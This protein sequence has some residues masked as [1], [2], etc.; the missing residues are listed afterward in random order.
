[1]NKTKRSSMMIRIVAVLAVTMMFTMCFVGGTFAKYV[2]SANVNDNQA[3]VA[4][5]GVA[6]TAQDTENTLFKTTYDTDNAS[7]SGSISNSVVSSSAAKL[8]A[9]GTEGGVLKFSVKGTPEVAVN[10]SF[11]M[12]VNSDV[13]IGKDSTEASNLGLDDA[14][15]TPV[16]FTLKKKGVV[17]PVA[18]G[19]LT[20]IKNYLEGATIS[21]D[22][23]AKTDLSTTFGE[24]ELTWAWAFGTGDTDVK[25]TYLGNVAA[26]TIT[27]DKV[28][29][30]IDFDLAITVTQID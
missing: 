1:M 11:A 30:T 6:V 21:K 18:Q 8:V 19:T 24:Y 2:T 23:A 5:W 12:T 16:V 25:D 9:P 7:V 29:T 14:D 3:Q 27:D 15:Y 20:D 10:V 4:K 28:S 17:T 22:Y 13:K 26:G